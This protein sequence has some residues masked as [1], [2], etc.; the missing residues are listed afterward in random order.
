MRP[1]LIFPSRDLRR[2]LSVLRR[3]DHLLAGVTLADPQ[4]HVRI[5]RA[6]RDRAALDVLDARDAL[7]IAAEQ[8]Y[9]LTDEEAALC[10]PVGAGR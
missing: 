9:R 4:E 2:A 10:A 3:L 8:G 6:V 1:A 7:L 5:W